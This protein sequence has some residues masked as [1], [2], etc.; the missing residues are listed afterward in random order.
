M[1]RAA[2]ISKIPPMSAE[3]IAA[4]TV[5][6]LRDTA[7]GPEVLLVR[8]QQGSGP[9]SGASVFPGGMVDRA[10]ADPEL[11][12]PQSGFVPDLALVAVGQSFSPELVPS[13]YVAA[14]RELFEEAGIL[15]ARNE[16]GR[17]V[18][19]GVAV[20]LA[21]ER[22]NLRQ[23]TVSLRALLQSARLVL[24]L[25]GLFPLAHWITPEH[26]ERR[27][28]TLFLLAPAPPGQCERADGAET[29]EAVWLRPADAIAAYVRGDHLLAPPTF[30]VLE[31]I[32]P[33]RSVSEALDRARAL[34][35]PPVILPVPL[36]HCSDLTLVLPGDCDYPDS[37]A[38]ARNR[39]VMHDGRWQ[40]IREP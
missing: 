10:D 11:A 38:S 15:F 24:A 17:P 3:P 16:S 6:M 35:P 20:A 34:G 5:V 9:F 32:S 27:W 31:E 26:Q 14:C 33:F 37:S 29:S 30:R 4:A 22:A 25:D 13:L 7:R 18:A 12:P 28:D 2:R 21:A 36:D 39:I 40:S 19:S 23:G 1:R 8:R